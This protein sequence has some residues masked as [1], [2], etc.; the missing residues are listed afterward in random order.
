MQVPDGRCN[1]SVTIINNAITAFDDGTFQDCVFTTPTTTATSTVTTSPTTTVT[2]TATTSATSTG[3]TTALSMRLTCVDHRNN[4]VGSLDADGCDGQSR[5][6][7]MIIGICSGV[8][9][10]FTCSSDGVLVD[11]ACPSGFNP[12]NHTPLTSFYGNYTGGASPAA[13]IACNVGGYVT[14]GTMAE[15]QATVDKLN[16]AGAS[17]FDGTFT[18]CSLSTPTTTATTSISTSQSTTPTTTQVSNPGTS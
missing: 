9:G 4:D 10:T 7:N 6:L 16:D 1:T 2:T 12:E 8:D 17:Y 14:L 3:T 15:C 11:G 13:P 18:D 5:L